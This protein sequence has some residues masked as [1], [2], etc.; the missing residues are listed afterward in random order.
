M[1]NAVLPPRCPGCGTILDSVAAICGSC[2][3]ALTFL[4]APQCQRCGAPFD[5]DVAERT[6][7]GRCLAD[8][9]VFDRAR[10]AVLYDDASRPLILRFK[11]GDAIHMTGVLGAWLARAGA[12]LLVDADLLVPVPLHRSRLFA[13]RYNQAALL[14]L[15]LERKTGILA[16]ALTLIRR[17]GT[18]S[19]GQLSRAQR[20]RNVRGAFGLED[21]RR[22]GFAGKRIV[23]IDDV[24]TS[25]ATVS[26]C[27]RAL[28]RGGA[29]S[30][31]VLTI[32]RVR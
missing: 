7:C 13:R 27:T 23:L 30:V 25:G 15:E 22:D 26:A 14:A 11:H 29:A 3:T 6:V 12:E 24:M 28:R 1:L 21:R 19:Q 31:D 2:W 17:R 20:E 4:G 10:A 5:F 8:P 9:P 32:A 18:P 16:D